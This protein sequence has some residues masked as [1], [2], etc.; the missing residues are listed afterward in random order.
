[1]ALNGARTANIRVEL[2]SYV[3]WVQIYPETELSDFT[4]VAEPTTIRSIKIDGH[5]Y[6]LLMRDKYK[7]VLI[8]NC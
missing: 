1:M 3:L 2:S 8:A 5:S 6:P 4:T 7:D